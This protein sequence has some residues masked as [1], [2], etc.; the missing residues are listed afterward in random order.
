[1]LKYRITILFALA[2]ITII[3]AHVRPQDAI[4]FVPSP[5]LVVERMLK[6][7]EV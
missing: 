5:M 4:P 1:M 2:V 3:P 6:L 7:A